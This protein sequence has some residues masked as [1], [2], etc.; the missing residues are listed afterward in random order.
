[1]SQ[2]VGF[3]LRQLADVA[4][5]AL[6]PGVNDPTTA[7]TCIGYLRDALERLAA[8]RFPDDVR[9]LDDGAVAIVEAVPFAELLRDSLVEIGWFAAGD[10]LVACRLLDAL[11]GIAAVAAE[12]GA[13]ERLPVVLEV[14]AEVASPAADEARTERDRRLVA[15]RLGRVRQAA[16]VT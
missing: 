2:D 4:L 15:E 13:R 6:S 16:G 5:R 1:V 8:R 9:R 10:T 11:A 7:L 3:G 14:A 12:A